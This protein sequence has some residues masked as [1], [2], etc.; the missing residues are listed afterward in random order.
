MIRPFALFALGTALLFATPVCAEAVPD[1]KPALAEQPRPQQILRGMVTGVDE[2]SDRLTV[3]LAEGSSSD[4]KVQD[5]L[6]FNAVRF[7]DEV[8]IIVEN[9]EGAKTIVGLKEE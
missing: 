7:G 1:D 9:V 5:A 8:E 4:F 3:R 2:R 6:V